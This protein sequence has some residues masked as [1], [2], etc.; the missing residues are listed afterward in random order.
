MSSTLATTCPLCGLRFAGRP[1]LELHMREDH[2]EQD[3]PAGTGHDDCGGAGTPGDGLGS[4]SGGGGLASGQAR[5]ADEEVTATTTGQRPRPG[6]AMTALRRVIGTLRRPARGDGDGQPAS[7]SD[8]VTGPRDSAA[9]RSRRPGHSRGG[10][11]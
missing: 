9:G 11:G 5:I 10:L 1:L 6:R 2:L 4:E 8:A 3:R 7:R